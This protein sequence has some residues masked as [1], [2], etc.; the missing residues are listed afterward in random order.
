MAEGLRECGI[1]EDVPSWPGSGS[2][3]AELIDHVDY[4]M[5]TGSTEVGKKVMERA[6]WTLHLWA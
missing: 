5:F 6:A 2:V 4:L 3:G 1:P